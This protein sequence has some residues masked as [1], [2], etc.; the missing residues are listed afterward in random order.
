M[1]SADVPVR[2]GEPL[3]RPVRPVRHRHPDV[4]EVAQLPP[5]EVGPVLRVQH[6]GDDR[7]QHDRAELDVGQRGPQLLRQLDQRRVPRRELDRVGELDVHRDRVEPVAVGAERRD[8][9]QPP[10]VAGDVA[11]ARQVPGH[12]L[13][14]AG[15]RPLEELAED[16]GAQQSGV[17]RVVGGRL[18]VERA[19]PRVGHRVDVGRRHRRR[20]TAELTGEPVPRQPRADTGVRRGPGDR[21]LRSPV[22][23][24]DETAVAAAGSS[25]VGSPAWSARTDH[26]EDGEEQEAEQ[27][28]ADPVAAQQATGAVVRPCRVRAPGP[29]HRGIVPLT[30]RQLCG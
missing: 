14:L 6:V 1:F 9:L 2:V 17:P 28:P 22:V 5:R 27:Q 26:G 12:H 13:H 15:V 3:L 19:H 8:L 16:V 7:R 30:R 23:G 29:A 10:Q 25:P 20:R 21:L 24:T 4:V 18:Q 11:E